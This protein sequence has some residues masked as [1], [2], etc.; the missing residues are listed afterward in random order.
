MI[1]G[2]G[3]TAANPVDFTPPTPGDGSIF[4]M[5]KTGFYSQQLTS[6][7]FPATR[8]MRAYPAYHP[9]NPNTGPQA[10]PPIAPPPPAAAPAAPAPGPSPAGTAGAFGGSGFGSSGG[11]RTSHHHVDPYT[12][13][14]SGQF[15]GISPSGRNIRAG[16][17]NA[18][19]R[20]QNSM[21]YQS[22]PLPPDAPPPPP[23]AP[24]PA[25]THGFGHHGRMSWNP[26]NWFRS[27]GHAHMVAMKGALGAA[28]NQCEIVGP[29]ADG[30]RVLICGGSVKMVID[31]NG[32]ILMNAFSNPDAY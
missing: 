2:T 21:P 27:P 17:Q 6:N 5:P 23:P 22:A 11:V 15:P 25:A 9:L 30:T 24:M 10:L 26:A 8:R 19:D 28:G 29:R 16:Y 32:N 31:A 18:G 7:L 12:V 20:V 1:L 14:R 13:M 3:P 4:P